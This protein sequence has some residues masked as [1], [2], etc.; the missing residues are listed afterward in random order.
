[1]TITFLVIAGCKPNWTKERKSRLEQ[2]PP[3]PIRTTHVGSRERKTP[4]FP[5]CVLLILWS[6]VCLSRSRSLLFLSHCFTLLCVTSSFALLVYMTPIILSPVVFV[7]DR[8]VRS[9]NC[10]KWVATTPFTQHAMHQIPPW[11]PTT[12]LHELTLYI[13]AVRWHATPTPS[14]QQQLPR[15]SFHQ[16]EK[17]GELWEMRRFQSFL[18]IRSTCF[19]EACS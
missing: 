6:C 3:K 17:N 11:L 14:K 10:M 2:D 12:N 15:C 16:G 1:M 9:W 5:P 7:A 19:A 8:D 18:T 13:Q 4:L